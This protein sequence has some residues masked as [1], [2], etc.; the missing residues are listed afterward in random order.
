VVAVPSFT[1]VPSALQLL[2]FHLAILLIGVPSAVKRKKF[3][4]TYT[5]LPL[6]AMALTKPRTLSFGPVPSVLQLLPFHLAILLAEIPPAALKF[7]PT[8][9]SLPLTAIA[10][11]LPFTPAPSALQLLPFHLA[12]LLTKVPPA[13]GAPPAVRKPPPTYTSLPLTA[14]A[15]TGPSTHCCKG[16]WEEGFTLCLLYAATRR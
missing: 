8:Y 6:T 9:T 16:H 3:P 10:K 7:P 4:P 14:R 13:A 15:L 11:T 2:P 5:S 1:P 12:I